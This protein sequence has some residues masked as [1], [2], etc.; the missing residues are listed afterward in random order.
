MY[1]HLVQSGAISGGGGDDDGDVPMAAAVV[2]PA[3]VVPENAAAVDAT[4]PLL[5]SAAAS[6]AAGTPGALAGDV[7]GPQAARVG[8]AGGVRRSSAGTAEEQ[9]LVDSAENLL[10]MCGGL[11]DPLN[12]KGRW[13]DARDEESM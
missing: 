2:P 10:A 12:K 4:P 5:S 7:H 3:P 6:A 1:Q 11:G 9:Q 13:A 8:A